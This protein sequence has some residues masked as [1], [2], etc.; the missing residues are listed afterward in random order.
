MGHD[1]FGLSDTRALHAVRVPPLRPR[2]VP[3]VTDTTGLA[4]R[5]R[6]GGLEDKGLFLS[7]VSG[8]GVFV[9]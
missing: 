4:H 1:S 7:R 3:Y 8:A 5:N 2:E 9:T 6:D